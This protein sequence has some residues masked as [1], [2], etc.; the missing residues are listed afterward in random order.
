M[1]DEDNA[2]YRMRTI[3]KAVEDRLESLLAVEGLTLILTQTVI[4]S[5]TRLGSPLGL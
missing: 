4:V 1:I 3:S 5:S 2:N